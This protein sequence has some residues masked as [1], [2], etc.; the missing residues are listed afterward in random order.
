[1][2]KTD[3]TT[4]PDNRAAR[5][6]LIYLAFAA[7]WILASDRLLTLAIED[8]ALLGRLG[9][10]KG[11]AFVAVTS[12]LLYLLM[13]AWPAMPDHPADGEF[14]APSWRGV[15]ATF[16]GLVLAVPLLAYGIVQLHGPEL[17]RDAL[18][19][20]NAIAELKAGQIETWL[21]ER[22]GNAQV[23]SASIG[24]IEEVEDY[25][26]TGDTRALGNLLVRLRAMREHYGFDVALLDVSGRTLHRD[27]ALA[28]ADAKPWRPSLAAAL[29]SGRVLDSN[30]KVDTDGRPHLDFIAP[31]R[32]NDARAVGGVVLRAPVR[33]F[34]YP[35]VHAWPTPSPS[36]ESYLIRRDGDHVLYLSDLRHR[37]APAMSLR[38]PLARVGEPARGALQSGAAAAI[39]GRD[40][41]DVAVLAVSRPVRG[42]DWHLVAKVDEDEIMAPLRNLVFWVSLVALA[43]TVCVSAAVLLL[44][45]AQTRAH[46]LRLLARTAE[47]DRLLR[48]FFDL[49]FVGM[50]ISSPTSKQWL[51]VNDRLCEILGYTREELLGKT[52]TEV[53]HPDDLEADL[54]EFQRVLDGA[55]EGYHIERRYLRK[56]GGVVDTALDVRCLRRADGMVEFFIATIEDISERKR[57]EAEIHRLNADLEQR[58]RQ[59]TAELEALNKELETFAY[60]VSHDLKAP[61]RGIDGYSR[62]LLEE[63]AA[64]LNEE[65]RQFLV[66]V[67]RGAEQMGE[68]IEDLLAYSRL[69][70]RDL[71]VGRLSPDEVVG[72]VVSMYAEEARARGVELRASVVCASVSADPDGLEMALRNLLD[73]AFKFSA[74]VAH[75]RVEI[76]GRQENAHCLLWVRDNGIG[77]DMKF[78]DRIF[79]IFQRLQRAEDY[80]GTGIGLSLARKAMRRMG[81]EVWADS[82]PGAGATFYLRLPA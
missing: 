66:N 29:A 27:E 28:G 12:V 46:G 34:L 78:H 75:P 71:R 4:R 36:A 79:E 48:R 60:S 7:L 53:T 8:S 74:G 16:L 13:R 20:L 15:L 51:Q 49:P 47:K 68:L 77:F 23:L 61:L 38:L 70:R 62:L 31:L 9:L 43:A 42:T 3:A 37:A 54:G 55:S 19:E 80:P 40:Y 44:W 76:G 14:A 10:L 65:G 25:A 45:R 82:A 64:A 67:R 17:R 57:A 73:N 35:L 32:L 6:A 72:K 30:L 41:R 59:R 11:L 24:F 52:W 39:E 56:D 22:R 1:M 21:D 33:E 81:G 5:V 63:H 26:R 50:A 58:V 69:E 2:A 18:A